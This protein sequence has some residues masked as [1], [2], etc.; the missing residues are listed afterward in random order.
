MPVD[1]WEI[2]AASAL[3]VTSGGIGSWVTGRQQKTKIAAEVEKTL[4]E[5]DEKESSSAVLLAE[6]Y[7]KLIDRLEIEQ[8]RQ[9]KMIDRL[10]REIG[11]LR[12]ELAAERKASSALM[13]ELA[14][15]R[16]RVT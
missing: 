6:A 11:T 2:C 8:A 12:D 15:L 16:A 1:L 14:T 7:G 4:A 10:E 3:T 5:A 13:Q 9:G